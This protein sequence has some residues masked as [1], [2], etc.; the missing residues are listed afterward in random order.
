MNKAIVLFV[1]TFLLLS[2]FEEE[3]TSDFLNETVWVSN[4][5]GAV[6]D[7]D[8]FLYSFIEIHT[9]TFSKNTFT[10]SFN[11]KETEGSSSSYNEKRDELTEGSYSVKYPE[12][13]LASVT[14]VK[15]CTLSSN[16]LT[17]NTG[18]DSQPLY[19]IRKTK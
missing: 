12:I 15:V 19:F 18:D 11:R 16:T 14:Y 13:T 17:M 5:S 1:L 6:L 8:K 7:G 3:A 4:N 10:Y 9:L 2:C